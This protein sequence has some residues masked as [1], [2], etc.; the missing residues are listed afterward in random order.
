MHL[1]FSQSLRQLNIT[2]APTTSVAL[3]VAVQLLM[4][5]TPRAVVSVVSLITAVITSA[6]TKLVTTEDMARVT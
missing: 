4:V 2:V 5:A 1:P 6:T 3:T